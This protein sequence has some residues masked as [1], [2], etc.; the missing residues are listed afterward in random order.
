MDIYSMGIVFFELATLSHPLKVSNV[1]NIL[2]WQDAHLFQ[3][4]Q[5]PEKINPNITPIFSQAILKMLEKDVSK[6][7]NNWD[8][9]RAEVSR[10]GNGHPDTLPLFLH[11][12]DFSG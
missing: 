8:E 1:N 5:K 12:Y 4:P 2:E 9:I 3:S 11:G 6:R 7:F 10:E